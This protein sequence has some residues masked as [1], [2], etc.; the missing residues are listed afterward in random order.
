MNDEFFSAK[1]SFRFDGQN[2]WDLLHERGLR[3]VTDLHS[4][5]PNLIYSVTKD[6]EKYALI[7]STGIYVH[8]ED[9]EKH[10]FVIPPGKM[11]YRCWTESDDL[12]TLFLVMFAISETEQAVVE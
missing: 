1:S 9:E 10:K 5:F 12:E 11:Y 6:G 2:I 7:E 4:I 3:L 8:E